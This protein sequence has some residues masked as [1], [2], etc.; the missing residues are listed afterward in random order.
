MLLFLGAA[1]IGGS[2]LLLG[3]MAALRP[4]VKPKITRKRTKKFIQHSQTHMSKLSVAGGSPEALTVGCV[5]N[6]GAGPLPSTGDG[7]SRKAARAASGFRKVL[8]H[9][10]RS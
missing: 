4:L 8:V 3:I 9:S 5:E 6:T 2:H 10:N 7:S 1:Y